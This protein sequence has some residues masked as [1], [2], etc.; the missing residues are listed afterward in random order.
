MSAIIFLAI[1]HRISGKSTS[2]LSEEPVKVITETSE[3]IIENKDTVETIF[4]FY[5]DDGRLFSSDP[6]ANWRLDIWQ[7]VIFDLSE[8]GKI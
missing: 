2:E 6:T 8:S 3:R 7:D 5:I 1:E 4:S